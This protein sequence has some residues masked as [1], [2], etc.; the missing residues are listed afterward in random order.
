MSGSPPPSQPR[1]A[2]GK[3]PRTLARKVTQFTRVH[4]SQLK[5]NPKAKPPQLAIWDERGRRSRRFPLLGDYFLLGRSSRK[6]D[7]PVSSEI[8]SQVHLSLTRDP[9]AL[10]PLF[11]LQD[12]G[13]TNGVYFR[14]RRV[15]GAVLGHRDAF[16]LGPPDLAD[17]VRVQY[18]APPPWSWLSQTLRYGLAIA[19]GSLVLGLALVAW[20]WRN[21]PVFP[22]P[23]AV[24][25]PVQVLAGDGETSLQPPQTEIHRELRS[26]SEFSPY[27]PKALIASEDA[28]FYWHFGIDPIGILRALFVNV[29]E[30]EIQQGGSTLSQQLARTLYRDYVGTENSA[31]RKYRE[32][33]AALKLET[34]YS[35][36]FLLLT[37]LNQ[38]F[39]G[40]SLYGFED[41][42]Q[43]YLDKSAS[44]LTLS[45]AAMLVG[46]LPAPNRFNPALNYEAA[47][48]RR[49]LVL[50]RM[51]SQGVVSLEAAREARRSRVEINPE[52]RERFKNTIAPYF[53]YYVLG[54]LERLLGSD[55]AREGN[56]WVETRL[57]VA[58]QDASDRALR[59]AL[60]G[61]GARSGFS[62]GAIVTVDGKTGAILAM[63][64]GKDFQSSQ[65]NR[66]S[67]AL[68][69]PG[70]TFKTI[71]Y[72]AALERG[73]SPSQTFSCAP[74]TWM[75]Q[76]YA[77]CRSGGGSLNLYAGLAQS[78][79]VVALRLAREVGLDR[80]IA[81][82]R[83][84]GIEAELRKSPGLVLGESEVP[85]VE[86][87]GAYAAL[88]NGGAWNRP[89]AVVRILDS[90]DCEN[91]DD[92]STCRVIYDAAI[93]RAGDR[94][95]LSPEAAATLADLLRGAVAGGTARPAGTV[96]DA[97]G[98][99]GTTDRSVDLWF[100][101]FRR[102]SGLTAGV[103]LGNDDNSPT[104][105]SSAQAA[106]VWGDYM[107]A[108]ADRVASY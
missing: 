81:M 38:V 77:G 36:D 34:F 61:T 6:C 13:S 26:L 63:T 83:D 53:Y 57:D 33:M 14:K 58:L 62:Q 20:E 92:P 102:D 39:L 82:A 60:D 101:G 75:G 99:T 41:A 105:G 30:G 45:E 104:R 9:D 32:A 80:V 31:G 11:V 97:A 86:M 47:V 106:A 44:D 42:A 5:L 107:R 79:N 91:F 96:P 22:L 8:A 65:F 78:E 74:L 68:R 35:K 72:A 59:A 4:F 2:L 64:G 73:I 10:R 15:R 27:L 84:L 29:T 25:G 51:V 12:C 46:I 67:Q 56:F 90:S 66:A 52:A 17:A 70:S 24:Q 3:L 43:F 28:R 19:G 55:L 16:T 88:A 54:E 93:D 1:T 40:G 94:R 89:Q 48:R 71:A 23:I 49:N 98:K 69:Q 21:I 100:V 37:Y 76:R 108:I 50:N 87:T 18:L 103:W 85:L 7:I 95:V